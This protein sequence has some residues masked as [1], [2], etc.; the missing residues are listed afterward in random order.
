MAVLRFPDSPTIRRFHAASDKTVRIVQGP[1]ESGKSVGV[2]VAGLYKAIITFPRS[3]DGIR[4]SRW[5]VWRQ[6]YPQLLGSTMTTWR[7]WFPESIYGKITGSEPYIQRLKFLDVDA[8]IVFQA[9]PDYT[10]KVVSDLKSTEWSGAWANEMQ[11]APRQLFVEINDRTGR[12]PSK[13]E[14]P[15][16][17][18]K[19]FHIGDMN[20]P[21]T[22]DHWVLYMRGDTPLP[23]DM[24]ED[25]KIALRKPEDWEFF[26]QPA[27]V[28]E[29]TTPD[30]KLLRYEINPRAENLVNMGEGQYLIRTQGKTRSEVMRDL[31]NKVVPMAKGTPRYPKFDRDWHVA[32]EEIEPNPNF[33]IILGLDFGMAPGCVFEQYIR[34]RWFCLDE[35]IATNTG[36]DEFAPMVKEVLLRRF[37][38]YRDAGLTAWG[39]PQGSWGSASSAKHE[40]TSY[41]IFQRHG[42]VVHSPAGAGRDNPSLRWETGR[43]C[44]D[45]TVNRA[46]KVLIDPR[47]R[48]LITALDGG[49]TMKETKIAGGLQARPEIVKDGH[50]HIC[51]AWEYPLWGGGEAN[52]LITTPRASGN[53][54]VQTFGRRSV[55]LSRRNR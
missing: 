21:H 27:A 17:N 23:A 19:V 34:G 30:G 15:A 44:L 7:K 10:D 22:F 13:D 41:A 48:R 40:N 51:E 32:K 3:V 11:F 46:P 1:V 14:C 9:F 25:E 39:D 42:I 4:R 6:S 47:C 37:P 31:G 52:E 20:A 50:S 29:V 54:P 8:E 5:L 2:G 36:S 26:V 53:K 55:F 45:A 38:F 24:P 28:K 35:L 33:P 12:Y 43:A 49:A 16:W 18:R